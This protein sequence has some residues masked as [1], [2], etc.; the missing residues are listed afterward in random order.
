MD[1]SEHVEALS[2]GTSVTCFG[3]LDLRAF[4]VGQGVGRGGFNKQNIVNCVT[5]FKRNHKKTYFICS[6]VRYP[7]P[8]LHYRKTGNR[9]V[10]ARRGC[11]YYGNVY[12]MAD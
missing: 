12:V 6:E 7:I 9:G 3:L 1:P 5:C 4:L 2:L 8:V 11:R 10:K